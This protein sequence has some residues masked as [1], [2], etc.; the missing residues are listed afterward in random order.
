MSHRRVEEL[1]RDR[2]RAMRVP[3]ASLDSLSPFFL[4]S[5]LVTAPATDNGSYLNCISDWRRVEI[6]HYAH[7]SLTAKQWPATE[8]WPGLSQPSRSAANDGTKEVP[9]ST[10]RLGE[11]RTSLHGLLPTPTSL[12][13]KE[14]FLGRS[15]CGMALAAVHSPELSICREEHTL[16]DPSSRRR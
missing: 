4:P 13:D 11:W 10:R 2:E 15:G 7:I 5:Y 8:P 3:S 9:G 6:R 14:G 1:L 12:P 16:V